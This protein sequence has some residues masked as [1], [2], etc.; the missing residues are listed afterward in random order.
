MDG[1]VRGT[2]CACTYVRVCVGG[3][4]GAHSVGG[5]WCLCGG[6]MVGVGGGAHVW[7]G[8]AWCVC[9]GGRHMDGD[10]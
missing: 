2:W 7:C 1:W 4:A 8:G 9:V 5:T 10:N 6:H 3:A